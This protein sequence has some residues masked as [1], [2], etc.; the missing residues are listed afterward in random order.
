MPSSPPSR[1]SSNPSLR[2]KPRA[3]GGDPQGRGVV[4]TANYV[5]RRFG[6]H[7]AMSCAEAR[8]RCRS[9]VFVPS[10]T[11]PLPRALAERLVD[12]PRGRAGRRADRDRRGLPRPQR[13]GRGLPRCP[14]E[15]AEAIQT[16]VR[17]TTKLTC[18]L[19]ISRLARSSRRSP[20]TGASP[21]GS[22]SSR[23]DARP[24][25]SAARRPQAAGRRPARR[26]RAA[27]RRGSRRS[28][29]WRRSRTSY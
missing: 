21:A 16:A 6:I 10:A 29:R 4:A 19:G 2:A 20:A 12:D 9:A 8:Q 5:A 24:S 25:S 13:R 26:A 28:A 11:R 17:G 3:G 14:R 15:L 23:R 18:S 22:P 7:S 1:S 27:R